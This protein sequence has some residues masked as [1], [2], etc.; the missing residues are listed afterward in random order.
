M[1]FNIQVARD[2]VFTDSR[3]EARG[4]GRCRLTNAPKADGLRRRLALAVRRLYDP[5]YLEFGMLYE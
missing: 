2:F 4:C 3:G 5:T 1:L